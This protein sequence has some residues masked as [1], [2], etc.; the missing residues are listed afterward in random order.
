[1]VQLYIK[2]KTKSKMI[3][4]FQCLLVASLSIVSKGFQRRR[5]SIKLMKTTDAKWGKTQRQFEK[6]EG[7][8][9][10][11]DWPTIGATYIYG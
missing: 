6:K 8:L 10:Y 4:M 2:P 3:H 5:I 9:L 11:S 7:V 1:M